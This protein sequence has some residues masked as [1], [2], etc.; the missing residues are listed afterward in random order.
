M[1]GSESATR[2]V[3]ATLP[4]G[5]PIKVEVAGPESGDGMTSV[6]LQDL[7]LGTALDTV[8]EIGSVLVEKLKAAKPTK[9][10]VELKLGFAVEAGK[11]TALWV[12]GKGE[13]AL[14][15]TLEWYEHDHPA[16]ASGR[17]A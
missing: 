6:G 2:T 4:S 10:T 16:K 11:L 9:A 15:V 17:N 1:N 12:G 13:A 3:T 8:G 7:K 5:V 14:T